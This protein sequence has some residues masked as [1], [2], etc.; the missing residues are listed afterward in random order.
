MSFAV[1]KTGGKQY[2]VA[3]GDKLLI[4]K[5]DQ[6]IGAEFDFEEIL[7]VS[8]GTPES[9]KIGTP[10]VEGAKVKARVLEHL[11]GEKKIVFKYTRKTRYKK[12]KGHRQP[13]TK[14]EILKITA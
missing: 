1:I 2:K 4:E 5:L 12:K 3:E 6:P 14:V 10:L 9:A 7:L 13:Y 11:K 8:D